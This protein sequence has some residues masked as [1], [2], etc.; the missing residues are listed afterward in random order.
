VVVKIMIVF[1]IPGLGVLRSRDDSNSQCCAHLSLGIYKH[2][3]KHSIK[4]IRMEHM[5][6]C[7]IKQK[8]GDENEYGKKKMG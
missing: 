1:K 6:R 3:I 8:R 5:N 2:K 7:K 4:H